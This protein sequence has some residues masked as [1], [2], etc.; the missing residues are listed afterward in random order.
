MTHKGAQELFFRG[1][2]RCLVPAIT[3]FRASVLVV[4]MATTGAMELGS[5]T[6]APGTSPTSTS[7][8]IHGVVINAL[9][10][11]PIARVLVQTERQAVLTAHDGRFEFADLPDTVTVVKAKKPGF[12]ESPDASWSAERFVQPGTTSE[13]QIR[14]YPE[15]VLTGTL[16][17]ASGDPLPQINVL[18]LRRNYDEMGPHWTFGGQT[19]T[20]ADGQFRITLPSGEY[21]V[22]TLYNAR[23]NGPPGTVLPTLSPNVASNAG[24]AITTLRLPSGLEQHLDLHAASR[25]VHIVHLTIE[26]QGDPTVAANASIQV[27]MA[28]GLTFSPLV[29]PA[30]KSG[31]LGV[32]LP[33]GSYL[34][35]ATSA[36]TSGPGSYGETKV[37]VANEDVYGATI[38]LQQPTEVAIE[39][40]IDPAANSGNADS[41]T[42]GYDP[43]TVAR[44]LGAFFLRT[45]AGVSLGNASFSPMPREGA[46][47]GFRLPPGSYRLRTSAFTQWYI[48]SANAGGTDLLTHDLVVNGGGSSLPLR[49]VVNNRSSTIKGTVQDAEGVYPVYVYLIAEAPSVS[50][51]IAAQTGQDGSFSR[52][53]IPP[54]SY[55]VLASEIRP[56][57]DLTDPAALAQLAHYIKAVTLAPGET[58]SVILSAVP[59]AEWQR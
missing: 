19:G 4:G 28:N 20:D 51:L 48:E 56:A 53:Q 42:S 8:S 26:G 6:G 16:T 43:G 25:P 14:L 33:N 49:I 40:A 24:G 46:P 2:L 10:G 38:R 57:L 54:G 47:F 12:Y 32:T 17:T 45:D 44:Q 55:R 3:I 35:G 5:Q 34:I 52:G 36:G 39:T 59:A 13:V 37:T 58:G 18:A 11:Q 41:G 23:R 15:A 21:V 30:V 50:P 1:W 22:E 9:T 31:E 29:S 27:H 7:S